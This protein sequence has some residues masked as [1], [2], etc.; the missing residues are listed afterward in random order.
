M[1]KFRGVK[2][3]L[4]DTYIAADSVA[5]R[6][7]RAAKLT[8]SATADETDAQGEMAVGV[9]MGAVTAAAT[10]RTVEVL[11]FGLSPVC[12]KTASG[13]AVMDRI[14]P[15]DEGSADSGKVEEAASADLVLGWLIEA[16]SAD[17]DEVLAMINQMGV[18]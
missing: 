9:F 10:A 17:D 15:S 7:Y 2:R 5:I 6:Q 12:V 16:P 3:I 18:L 11:H 13:L 14:T 1:S 8:D 4:T